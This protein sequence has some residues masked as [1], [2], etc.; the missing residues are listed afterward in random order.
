MK[1]CLTHIA[2]AVR[3]LDDS[4]GFYERYCGFKVV[5]DRGENAR[6]VV[7][8]AQKESPKSMILVMMQ[9]E[10]R[11]PQHPKDYSHLGLPSVP[12]QK[13]TRS[14]SRQ[15]LRAC[16]CGHQGKSRFLWAITVG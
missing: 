3:N 14:L 4:I 9:G 1:P 2:M 15:R 6:R 16:F 13:S 10:H 8:L 11:M 12:K 5:H 7:W